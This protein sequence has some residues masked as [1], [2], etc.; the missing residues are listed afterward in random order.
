MRD[1]LNRNK[2]PLPSMTLGNLVGY[3]VDCQYLHKLPNFVKSYASTEI[4]LDSLAVTGN[5]TLTDDLTKA[6]DYRRIFQAIKS[7][8]VIKIQKNAQPSLMKSLA[9]SDIAKSS[10]ALTFDKFSG[11]EFNPCTVFTA[12]TELTIID[13]EFKTYNFAECKSLEIFAMTRSP[14]YPVTGTPFRPAT[15][16]PPV[17]IDDVL[18]LFPGVTE[19]Q[20]LQLN[21]YNHTCTVDIQQRGDTFRQRFPNLKTISTSVAVDL[22][23]DAEKRAILSA[24]WTVS[25]V[26]DIEYVRYVV[27]ESAGQDAK[28]RTKE[29]QSLCPTGW[30]MLS[31]AEAMADG[32]RKSFVQCQPS[33]NGNQCRMRICME[34]MAKRRSSTQ[35]P[36]MTL[37]NFVSYGV[38]QQKPE[39]LASFSERFKEKEI[40]LDTLA[41]N[42][43]PQKKFL[44]SSITILLEM[45]RSPFCESKSHGLFI[46]TQAEYDDTTVGYFT[47]IIGAINS[48]QQIKLIE[49]VPF[50]LMEVLEKSPLV[51]TTKIVTFDSYKEGQCDLCAVFKELTALI[52]IDTVFTTYK[53][54]MCKSLDTLA[55]VIRSTNYPA[56]GGASVTATAD[57]NRPIDFILSLFPEPTD[58]RH[59][60]LIINDYTSTVGIMNRVNE[61]KKRFPKLKTIITSV[62]KEISDKERTEIQK[63]F[64]IING[65]WN[66]D[67]VRYVVDEWPGLDVQK[68]IKVVESLCPN[69]LRIKS[70]TGIMADGLR[71]RYVQCRQ[72]TKLMKYVLKGMTGLGVLRKAPAPNNK[73]QSTYYNYRT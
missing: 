41:L 48:T 28:T 58:I 22:S 34:D 3:G 20:D 4:H 62:A 30:G 36:S 65:K 19:I 10:T 15:A 38:G 12:L 64:R 11:K 69:E 39:Q 18:A 70:S 47:K 42:G 14:N 55:M 73:A 44:V 46:C 67:H 40:N 66:L 45:M 26:L 1:K 13:T 72:K 25:G 29:I 21:F 49:H 52:F 33:S 31:S 37:S 8:K 54:K 9:E 24:M 71:K 51:D 35:K 6:A 27:D 7:T 2:D 5:S 17:P 56:T 57:N 23:T 68:R 50:A 32:S 53:F 61:F 16:N 43:N 63:A 60:Q 59:L